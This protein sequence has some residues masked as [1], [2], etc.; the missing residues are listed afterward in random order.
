MCPG[1][2][3]RESRSS[4]DIDILE[5]ATDLQECQCHGRHLQRCFFK[6]PMLSPKK[7]RTRKAKPKASVGLMHEG[8]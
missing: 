1:Y 7:S 4:R 3:D 8:W 6:V 5:V 2:T